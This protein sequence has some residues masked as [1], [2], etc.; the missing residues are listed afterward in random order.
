MMMNIS[1]AHD[2][3]QVLIKVRRSATLLY[4]LNSRSASTAKAL[5]GARPNIA[6]SRRLAPISITP[7][8]AERIKELID[9]KEEDVAGVHLSV[10][11]RGCNGYSYIMNYA[12][13]DQVKE[14]KDEIVQNHG[15]TVLVDPKATFFII[16]TS[17][18]YNETE[19]ASEFTFINPN[20]KGECGCGESFNI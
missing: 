3:R 13:H 6:Q 16:G 9:G 2:L 15:V 20:V 11:R 5:K 17:M 12:S 10:K 14:G 4:D 1:R 19:L 7:K 8:A 18:D